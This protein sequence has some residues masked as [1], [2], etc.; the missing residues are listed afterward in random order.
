M[1]RRILHEKRRKSYGVYYLNHK[2]LTLPYSSRTPKTQ[3]CPLKMYRNDRLNTE[4]QPCPRLRIEDRFFFLP[5]FLSRLIPASGQEYVQC[6]Q[7]SGCIGCVGSGLALAWGRDGRATLNR[8]EDNTK[9][10]SL[11]VRRTWISKHTLKGLDLR[12][13]YLTQSNWTLK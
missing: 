10:D 12:S 3:H 2:V 11:L 1:R 8:Q 6:K 7:G 9:L 13:T 5:G 4:P